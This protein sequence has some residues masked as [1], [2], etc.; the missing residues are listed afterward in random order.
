MPSVIN[1]LVNQRIEQELPQLVVNREKGMC[2]RRNR[3]PAIGAILSAVSTTLLA[4]VRQK[5]GSK[6]T[7]SPMNKLILKERKI[8]TENETRNL[9]PYRKSQMQALNRSRVEV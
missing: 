2:S 5:P 8:P 6:D 9:N 3:L 7:P 1:M 4:N